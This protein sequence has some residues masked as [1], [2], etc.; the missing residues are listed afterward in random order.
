LETIKENDGPISINL[1]GV[2]N[3]SVQFN[4]SD[5]PFSPSEQGTP[6]QNP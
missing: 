2:E 1:F 4:Q 6:I 3:K 5:Q